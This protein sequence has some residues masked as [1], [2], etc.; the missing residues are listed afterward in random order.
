MPL[1]KLLKAFPEHC[2]NNFHTGRACCGHDALP[3]RG[4]HPGH[5]PFDAASLDPV[6][7]LALFNHNASSG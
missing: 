2:N 4:Q 1:G 6:F 5:L 3:L 7:A